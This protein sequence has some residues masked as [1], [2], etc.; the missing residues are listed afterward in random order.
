VTVNKAERRIRREKKTIEAM[1]ELYCRDNH[2]GDEGLCKS[3]RDLLD[4]A[5]ERLDRCQLASNK[6]TCL[7]CSI[8]CYERSRKE[9]VRIVMRYSGPR[10]LRRHPILAIRHLMD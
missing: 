6:P 2:E 8:H 10:M 7:D 4:Y 1:I 3:C 9:E 5:N